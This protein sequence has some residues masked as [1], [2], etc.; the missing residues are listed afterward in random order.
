MKR[1]CGR[2]HVCEM[3]VGDALG[4]WDGRGHDGCHAC[5]MRGSNERSSTTDGVD[6]SGNSNTLGFTPFAR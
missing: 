4:M 3:R 5:G 6:T 2:H 1:G